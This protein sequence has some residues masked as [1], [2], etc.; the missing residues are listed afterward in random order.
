[1]HEAMVHGG[2]GVSDAFVASLSLMNHGLILSTFFGGAGEDRGRSVAV[3]AT[4]LWHAGFLR[5]WAG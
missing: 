5:P 4:G 2:N 3:D 1:M